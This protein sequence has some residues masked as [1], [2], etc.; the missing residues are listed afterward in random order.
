ML[1]KHSLFGFTL[2]IILGVLLYLSVNNHI[3]WVVFAIAGFA[4]LL[5]IWQVPLIQA[6]LK[7]EKLE[8]NKLITKKPHAKKYWLTRLA[9]FITLVFMGLIIEAVW[10]V[11]H[12]SQ[13]SDPARN[14]P[15]NYALK[16]IKWNLG[17]ASLPKLIKIP[18]GKFKMGDEYEKPIHSVTI[19]SAFYMSQTEV[20]FEQ[21]DY[22]IWHIR[23][24]GLRGA[25]NN[26]VDNKQALYPDDKTWGRGNLPVIN[27][28]WFDATAYT[29]WLSKQTNRQCRLPSEA[30]WEYAARA[31]TTTTYSWGNKI[32]NNNANCDGCGSQWDNKQTAPVASF[33]ANQFGLYD[34]H[35]NVFE[36]VE[37][38][39]HDNYQNAPDNG[40]VWQKAECDSRVLRGGSWGSSP[41]NLRSA[42][43]SVNLPDFRDFNIG[44]RVVC[45]LPF[46]EN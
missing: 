28:S 35:G 44:F 23:Q 22:Y 5:G 32:G 7:G 13:N 19:G 34:M 25:A 10:W 39:Y 20:T 1:W 46:T 18:A 30:E 21:Y 14:L 17:I 26:S 43:R 45:S 37:D 15:L 11:Q 2:A 36:W 27:V 24:N 12:T 29:N 9:L 42:S 31:G 6:K 40:T 4:A 8:T 41:F 3:T 33:S 16:K 38:C